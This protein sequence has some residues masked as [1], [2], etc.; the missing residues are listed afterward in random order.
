MVAV[1]PYARDA[2]ERD[3]AALGARLADVSGEPAAGGPQPVGEAL[4]PLVSG[5]AQ[6][7]H[8]DAALTLALN[9]PHH[10]LEPLP[11]A[12]S[13][14]HE[15]RA[16]ETGNPPSCERSGPSCMGHGAASGATAAATC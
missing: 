5:G 14:V 7:R 9:Q 13:K 8:L 10:H 6:H 16:G 1:G 11:S 2:G 4:R 12:G 15:A 3:H